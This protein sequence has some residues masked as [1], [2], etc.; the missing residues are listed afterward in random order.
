MNFVGFNIASKVEKKSDVI[1]LGFL[2]FTSQKSAFVTGVCRLLYPLNILTF[3]TFIHSLWI[4]AAEMPDSGSETIP[5][6]SIRDSSV[7]LLSSAYKYIL[8]VCSVQNL[9]IIT[10]RFAFQLPKFT[11]GLGHLIHHCTLQY[12]QY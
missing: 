2:F 1:F 4:L 12:T 9:N 10:V 7:D 6:A 11:T 5:A 3:L 8:S